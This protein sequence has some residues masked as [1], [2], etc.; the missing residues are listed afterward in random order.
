MVCI[1][2]DGCVPLYRFWNFS[3]FETADYIL[4]KLI[5]YG[6][7]PYGKMGLCCSISFGGFVEIIFLTPIIAF[8]GLAWLRESLYYLWQRSVAYQMLIDTYS[9]LQIGCFIIIRFVWIC[10]N[11]IIIGS[12]DEHFK[13]ILWN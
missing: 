4:F 11:N 10:C 6:C 7:V 13:V 12:P 5:W 8:Q 2:E 3:E 9:L 1:W